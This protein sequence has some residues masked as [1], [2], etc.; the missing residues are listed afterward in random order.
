MLS[1]DGEHDEAEAEA[2]RPGDD[3]SQISNGGPHR[4][5]RR[6]ISCMHRS[7]VAGRRTVSITHVVRLGPDAPSYKRRTSSVYFLFVVW[8]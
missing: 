1:A 3:V 5:H 4:A 7:S 2:A 8:S 6:N